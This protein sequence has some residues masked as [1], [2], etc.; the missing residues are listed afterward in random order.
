LLL[1][2]GKKETRV[3]KVGDVVLISED[4]HKRID[5]SLARVVEIIPGQNGQGR[6]LVLKI[7]NG[8]LKRSIRRIYPLEISPDEAD[9]AKDVSKRAKL[10]QLSDKTS[11]KAKNKDASFSYKPEDCETKITTRR[12][13]KRPERFKY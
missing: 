3:I 4:T 1:K 5:W 2:D 7:K 6:V 8:M 10:G 13:I 9:F 11:Q 12:V